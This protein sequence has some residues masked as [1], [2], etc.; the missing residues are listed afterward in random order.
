VGAEI[1]AV[2][3]T[4]IS[5]Q[6]DAETLNEAVLVDKSEPPAVAVADLAK[7]RKTLEQEGLPAKSLAGFGAGAFAYSV[8]S[9]KTLQ[10]TLVVPK[11][12]TYLLV[13]APGSVTT[14]GALVR[15]L[16]ATI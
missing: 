14:V 16:L 15:G 6:L 7:D 3:R 9:G 11:K 12:G 4:I 8:G 13:E 10:S 5:C 2:A 1:G